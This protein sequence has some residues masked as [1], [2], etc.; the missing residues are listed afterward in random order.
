M[1]R[2]REQR[3]RWSPQ[4]GQINKWNVRLRA[5]IS[6]Q[7]FDIRFP[8]TKLQISVPRAGQGSATVLCKARDGPVRRRQAI[9]ITITVSRLRF[10]IR[11][12]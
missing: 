2:V 8:E 12:R 6:L 5:V 1:Y 3:E 9:A 4:L 10:A 7:R 11:R